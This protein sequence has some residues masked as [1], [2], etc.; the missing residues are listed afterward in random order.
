[1]ATLGRF[2]SSAIQKLAWANLDRPWE[3]SDFDRRRNHD[4][5][6]AIAE[7]P[8]K[9]GVHAV[10]APT[11]LV[12]NVNAVWRTFDLSSEKQTSD[13]TILMSQSYAVSCLK[14]K[15]Q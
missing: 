15:T 7:F 5:A 2:G 8:V 3:P 9:A 1:M 13:L 11:H 4:A 10:L 12:E 6:K 14:K